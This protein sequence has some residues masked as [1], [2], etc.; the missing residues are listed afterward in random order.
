M[1]STFGR[2]QTKTFNKGNL[3]APLPHRPTGLAARVG[4]GSEPEIG[5]NNIDVAAIP[6]S[7]DSS[8][9]WRP[10]KRSSF[11]AEMI[12]SAT[13]GW[14]MLGD[15]QNPLSSSWSCEFKHLLDLWMPGSWLL[16]SFRRFCTR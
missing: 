3:L 9:W 10:T 11:V 13:E 14:R 7:L 1:R 2:Q 16:T 4:G 8:I 15:G 5:H 12:R 6:P